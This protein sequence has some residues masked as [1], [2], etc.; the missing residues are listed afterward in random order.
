[1]YVWLGIALSSVK[2]RYTLFKVTD[3]SSGNEARSLLTGVNDGD[4][5]DSINIKIILVK[6]V[7]IKR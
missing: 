2:Y 5:R 4:Q 1:M 7:K 6:V 3:H